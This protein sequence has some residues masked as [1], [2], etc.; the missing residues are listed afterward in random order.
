MSS[1]GWVIL[2]GILLMGWGSIFLSYP[3]KNRKQIIVYV[4]ITALICAGAAI[5]LVMIRE[6]EKIRA[7]EQQACFNQL[8]QIVFKSPRQ[9]ADW[10]LNTVRNEATLLAAPDYCNILSRVK[11]L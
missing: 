2:T 4:F 8:S 9:K 6:N 11:D 3:P 5:F 10:I 7:N 1:G